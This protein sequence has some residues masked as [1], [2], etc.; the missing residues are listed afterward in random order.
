[1]LL[2]IIYNPIAKWKKLAY[3]IFSGIFLFTSTYFILQALFSQQVFQGDFPEDWYRNIMIYIP[4][5][6]SIALPLLFYYYQNVEQKL[7]S[8]IR[9]LFTYIYANTDDIKADKQEK[10]KLERGK[11][12]NKGLKIN[13]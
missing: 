4:V 2:Y 9:A 1:M 12:I 6:V 11:L 3:S 13:V 8:Y 10:H 7:K 5:L